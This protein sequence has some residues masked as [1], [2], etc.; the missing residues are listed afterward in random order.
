MWATPP[1]PAPVNRFAGPESSDTRTTLVFK[2]GVLHV[3]V[4]MSPNGSPGALFPTATML[5]WPVAAWRTAVQMCGT[6]TMLAPGGG[7]ARLQAAAQSSRANHGTDAS[8][9]IDLGAGELE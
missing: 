5:A 2:P 7:A 1:R 4:A 3:I 6:S 9:L 8:R